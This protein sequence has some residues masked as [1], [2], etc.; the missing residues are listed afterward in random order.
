MAPESFEKTE[1]M[2]HSDLYE[3]VVMPFGLCN[4][5]STFQRLM[6]RVLD[7]LARDICTVY[8]GDMLVMAATFEEHLHNLKSVFDCLQCWTS[9]ET[10]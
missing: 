3:F 4:A 2:T 6:E 5:P 8:L 9:L 7:G 1:F 10:I